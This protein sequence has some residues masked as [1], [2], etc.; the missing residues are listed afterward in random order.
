MIDELIEYENR[1]DT[2]DHL[3][4]IARQS[5]ENV[6]NIFLDNQI[7]KNT[8]LK[9]YKETLENLILEI[10]KYNEKID[11]ILKGSPEIEPEWIMYKLLK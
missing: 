3:I 5:I 7:I 8:L 2:I 10:S 9:Q 4:N 1:I 6:S 11:Y